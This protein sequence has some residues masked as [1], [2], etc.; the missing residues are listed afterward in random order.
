[1]LDNIYVLE[2]SMLLGCWHCSLVFDTHVCPRLPLLVL[3]LRARVPRQP[4]LVELNDDLRTLDIGL[5]RCYQVGFVAAL[6]FH[7]EK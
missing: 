5:A 4:L 7:E 2:E 3:V 6:P 1:M